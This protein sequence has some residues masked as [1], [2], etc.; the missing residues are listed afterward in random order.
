MR[1]PAIP[2]LLAL[3]AGCGGG[4]LVVA[5]CDGAPPDTNGE[6]VADAGAPACPCGEEPPEQ[7]QCRSCVCSGSAGTGS[8]LDC[9]WT[10]VEGKPV[11]C[12]N[13]G[14]ATQAQC[15]ASPLVATTCD[16]A[17]M[18]QPNGVCAQ[19]APADAGNAKAT[20]AD[21]SRDINPSTPDAGQ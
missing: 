9:H 2:L 14:C 18:G 4:L 21:P 8:G 16:G 10:L 17:T 19:H 7:A 5:C 3:V 13:E 11:T 15:T 20:P 1:A 6:C 12:G